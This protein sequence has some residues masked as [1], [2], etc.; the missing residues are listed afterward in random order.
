MEEEEEEEEELT[1]QNSSPCLIKCNNIN[2]L[3]YSTG[4]AKIRAL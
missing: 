1:F 4:H 2:Q 3:H